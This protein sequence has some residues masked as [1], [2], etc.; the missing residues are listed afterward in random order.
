MDSWGDGW[1]NNTVD[2]LVNGT[3][4]L[5]DLTLLGGS[6]GS[7]TIAVNTGDNITT[8]WNGGGSWPTE[9]SYTISNASGVQVAAGNYA[10]NISALSVICPTCIPSATPYFNN[11]DAG[12]YTCWFQSADDEFDWNLNAFSTP[13]SGTGPSSDMTG[14]GYYAYIETSYPRIAGDQAIIIS[15]PIDLSSLSIPQ[16]RFYTHMYGASVGSLSIDISTDN[17]NTYTNIFSK[18]GNQGNIWTE[19]LVDISSYTGVAT[20]RMTG[21]R[22][23]NWDGDIAFDNFE[24]RENPIPPCGLAYQYSQNNTTSTSNATCI[25]NESGIE[26]TYYYNNAR[27]D[28]LLFAIAH[29]PNNLGNNSFTATVDIDVTNDPVNPTDFISG[30]FKSEDVMNQ[31]CYIAMGRHWNVTTSGALIDPVNIRFYYH[32]DELLAVTDAANTWMTNNNNAPFAIGVG[33]IEWFKTNGT[34]YNPASVIT[35][36]ALT[37]TIDLTAS[38]TSGLTSSTGINYVQI[39]DVTSFSGGTAAVNI[40]RLGVLD[41]TLTSFKAEKYETNKSLLTW[42][43]EREEDMSHYEIQRSTNGIQYETIGTTIP[44]GGVGISAFYQFIDN[45]PSIGFNYYRL[46]MVETNGHA[47]LS[48]SRVLEFNG[49]LSDINIMPNPFVNEFNIAVNSNRN[50]KI[51]IIIFNSLGQA[52]FE[53]SYELKTGNNTIN[54]KLDKNLSSGTYYLNYYS[55]NNIIYKKIIKK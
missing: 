24:I 17:G 11:F 7:I 35:P 23:S 33:N 15:E 20:F 1:N 40:S 5:D 37:N 19:E 22:G 16:L 43:T 52:F 2:I 39:N 47:D 13:S 50:E 53:K 6:S 38:A 46:K 51:D 45:S 4:V 27:P 8:I 55:N 21:T 30:V 18:S 28:E 49:S 48:Q 32:P 54:I 9:C 26:W 29:D 14:S 12:F 44:K 31:T 41:V 10:T 3:P 42:S 25:V 36:A 34:N